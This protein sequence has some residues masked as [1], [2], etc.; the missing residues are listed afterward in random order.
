MGVWIVMTSFG[1]L[2][3]CLF[4]H[5]ERVLHLVFFFEMY[6]LFSNQCCFS[7]LHAVSSSV[8]SMYPT[9]YIYLQCRYSTRVGRPDLAS[10]QA[11]PPVTSHFN[12]TS[13]H[14]R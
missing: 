3:F 8:C 9:L 12:L 4:L 1:R 11:Q 2:S 10:G 5:C 6:E 14:S 7:H 13:L